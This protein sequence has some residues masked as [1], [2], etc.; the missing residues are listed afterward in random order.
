MYTGLLNFWTHHRDRDRDRD[1]GLNTVTVT[2][3]HGHGHGVFILA[4]SSKVWTHHR[5]RDRDCGLITVTETVT[6]DSSSGWSPPVGDASW[7]S[8]WCP[9]VIA[10]AQPSAIQ[11]RLAFA[12]KEKKH[13]NVHGVAVAANGAAKKQPP[14]SRKTIERK[15][16]ET[17]RDSHKL[18]WVVHFPSWYVAKKNSPWPWPWPWPWCSWEKRA[19]SA[20]QSDMWSALSQRKLMA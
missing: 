17:L 3:G 9:F 4:T 8:G 5:D 7:L 19:G 15:T 14:L 1:C 13:Q 11:K 12:N 20:W 2:T 10:T 18:G 16:G 6:L